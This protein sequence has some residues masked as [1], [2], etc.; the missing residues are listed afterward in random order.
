[1]LVD[2]ILLEKAKNRD[3]DAFDE[4]IAPYDKKIVRICMHFMCN[5]Q[6]AE[7]AAL[8]TEDK[9]WEKLYTYTED[10]SFEGFILQIAKNVCRNMLKSMRAKKRGRNITVFLGGMQAGEDEDLTYDLPDP[11]QNVEEEVIRRQEA[12]LLRECMKSLPEELHDALLLTQFQGYE[13]SEAAKELGIPEG[14]VKNRVFR[15]KKKLKKMQK[16]WDLWMD[17]EPAKSDNI[18]DIDKER[19]IRKQ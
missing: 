7:D 5:K 19:G 8:E 10:E 15:A 11:T 2:R 6:D 17:Y 12:D 16:I 1:M 13:Y 4:L 18:I 3:A 9:L 14:T